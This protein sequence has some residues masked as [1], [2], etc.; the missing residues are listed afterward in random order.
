[1]CGSY[2]NYCFLQQSLDRTTAPMPAATA[3][4]ELTESW[5]QA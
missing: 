5:N 1:V 4:P 3:S 2:V